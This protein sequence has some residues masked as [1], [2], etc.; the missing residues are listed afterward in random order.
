MIDPDL[1]FPT[2]TTYKK[3]AD[4]RKAIKETLPRDHLFWVEAAAGGTVGLP[5]LFVS[6][7]RGVILP[8]E[9]KCGVVARDDK[10]GQ[11]WWAV[12]LRPSQKKTIRCLHR[13]GATPLIV[14][15][16]KGGCSLFVVKG[17]NCSYGST[18]VSAQK[19]RTWGDVLK[20][21]GFG[22]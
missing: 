14:I 17:E 21:A 22:D 13:S 6:I 10:N 18:L 5:D 19:V 15:G 12:D 2:T 7:G 11:T 1:I 8:I 3:E 16:V 9:L 20:E 4:V